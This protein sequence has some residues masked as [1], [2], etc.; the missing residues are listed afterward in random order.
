[1]TVRI[2]IVDGRI[3]ASIP[4]M[5]GRGRDLARGIAGHRP[6]SD[7]TVDPPKFRY[8]TYPLAMS[9]CRVFRETFGRDLTIGPRLAEWAWDQRRNEEALEALRAGDGADLPRVRAEAP[10]LWAA[11]QDRPFQIAGAAFVTKG[12]RVCLGDE[13]RP[14]KTYQALASIVESNA[15]TILMACPRTATRSVWMRKIR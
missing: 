6:V 14:G 11:L 13:P 4:W 1:M 2:E 7:K 3:A 15:R 10:A 12:M 8:W 5:G 9:T